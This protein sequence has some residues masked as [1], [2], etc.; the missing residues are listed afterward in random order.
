MRSA[1]LQRA[2][3]A[4]GNQHEYQQ[5]RQRRKKGANV[6]CKFIIGYMS[7]RALLFKE[8]NAKQKTKKII[9][10]ARGE[11]LIEMIFAMPSV[12]YTGPTRNAFYQSFNRA[13]T[14]ATK[15]PQKSKLFFFLYVV[16]RPV[17]FHLGSSKMRNSKRFLCAINRY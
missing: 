8:A 3:P 1:E 6:Y 17:P 10:S 7:A 9:R 16:R 2:Q 5:Q 11:E 4:T 15:R 14:R 12:H 13:Q